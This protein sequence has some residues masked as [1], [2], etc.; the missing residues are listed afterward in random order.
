MPVTSSTSIGKLFQCVDVQCVS[1]LVAVDA[2]K[3]ISQAAYEFIVESVGS[4][5][6]S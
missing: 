5:C 4:M 2:K 3:S 1:G 6:L